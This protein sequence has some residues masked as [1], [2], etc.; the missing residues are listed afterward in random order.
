MCG[1][2]GIAKID[3]VIRE[4]SIFIDDS[5]RIMRHRGPDGNGVW[6]GN[7]VAFGHCRLAIIDLVKGAQPMHDAS[8]RFTITYNGEIYNY[9]ELRQF[10]K[11]KGY[12]FK[13]DSDTEVIL[14]AYAHWGSD[15]LNEFNGIFAFGLWDSYERSL[16]LARDHVGVKPLVYYELKDFIIFSSEIKCIL[17]HPRIEKRINLFALSDYLSLGYILNPKTIISDIKKLPPATWL[18]WKNGTSRKQC[19]WDI[20]SVASRPQREFSSEKQAIEE[21]HCELDRAVKLQQVS[22]VPTGAFLS[23]GIDSSAI[24][25]KMVS[26][27]SEEVKTFSIGFKEKS[28]NEL[29]Y[30]RTVAKYLGTEHY[31]EIVD[32][33]FENI[34]PKLAW[35]YDEPFSDT[36]CLPTYMLSNLTGNSVKVAFSGDGGDECFAGYDTFIADKLQ[37]R[38]QRL[39]D[40]MKRLTNCF[41]ESLPA[42]HKKVNWDYKLKQF[43]KFAGLSPDQAHYSWRTIFS[44]EEKKVLLNGDIQRELYGYTPY[45]VFSDYFGKMDTHY[46]LNRMTCVDFQTWLTDAMLVKVDRASMANSLEVRVPLL[47]HKL[48]EFAFSLPQNMKIKGYSTKYILKKSMEPFLPFSI[49]HR[50]KRGFNSP[51]AKWVKSF[52]EFME[53]HPCD[54]LIGQDSMWVDLMKSHKAHRAD[55]GFKLWTLL[56][57]S[58]W[59]KTL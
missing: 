29:P 32:P 25:Q 36:S 26:L 8:G 16:L 53:N 14:N 18:L 28:F 3:S 37:N 27:N 4:D 58:L 13:T 30:A 59:K 48:V 11:T 10:L 35:Y 19:Y 23:G 34:L 20:A 43:V 2:V 38:Y 5:V 49:V 22:D 44:E 41:V 47:D 9:R 17:K 1:I 7:N 45:D 55:N 15:C 51:V 24:V 54:Y 57:W 31:D 33:D 50:K 21:L 40:V 42:T 52:S 46:P 39:P 56:C 12:V 6:K